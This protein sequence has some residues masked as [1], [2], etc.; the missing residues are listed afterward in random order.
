MIEFTGLLLSGSDS[1]ASAF[2]TEAFFGVVCFSSTAVWEFQPHEHLY[3]SSWL[4]LEA[5]PLQ[6][7]HFIVKLPALLPNF[8]EAFLMNACASLI[9]E[10]DASRGVP[11]KVKLT[12]NLSL[13]DGP[14][15]SVPPNIPPALPDVAPGWFSPPMPSA[16]T[17]A[18]SF[19]LA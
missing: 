4:V 14:S 3:E 11:R 2:L 5:C 1:T 6:D 12:A 7:G 18:D 15:R 8:A 19:L 17:V 9:E 10:N 13:K 16:S